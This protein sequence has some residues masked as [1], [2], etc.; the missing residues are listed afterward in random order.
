M[1]DTTDAISRTRE[2]YLRYVT[3]SSLGR[4]TRL[5]NLPSKGKIKRGRKI[6]GRDQEMKRKRERITWKEVAKRFIVE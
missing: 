3:S 2:S 4:E 6:E 1:I 5:K